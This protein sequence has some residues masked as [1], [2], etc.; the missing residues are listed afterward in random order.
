[1]DYLT[2][3]LANVLQNL[4]LPWTWVIG[5]ATWYYHYSFMSFF[6]LILDAGK[7]A[8]AGPEIEIESQRIPNELY[9]LPMT[10]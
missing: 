4:L 2:S 7:N 5:T 1:M 3:F 9:V 8:I 6:T 10:G